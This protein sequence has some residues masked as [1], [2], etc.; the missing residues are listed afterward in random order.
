MRPNIM[1]WR[2]LCCSHCLVGKW[3]CFLLAALRATAALFSLVSTYPHSPF[4]LLDLLLRQHQSKSAVKSGEEGKKGR[5]KEKV[6]RAESRSWV[7]AAR[8][9]SEEGQCSD[10]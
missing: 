3:R 2:Y 9:G 7:P 6:E 4:Q 10:Q 8:G 5:R 1:E